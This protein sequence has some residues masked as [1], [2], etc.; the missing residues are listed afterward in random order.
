MAFEMRVTKVVVEEGVVFELSLVKLFGS[1]IQRAL[2]NAEGFLLVE[3]PN[4]QEVADLEYETLGLQQERG[5]GFG[6][7]PV[8]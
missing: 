7:L 2:E 5:L 8:E 4:C 1:E 3:K 6:D